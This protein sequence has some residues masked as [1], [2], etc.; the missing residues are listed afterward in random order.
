MPLLDDKTLGACVAVGA[1][2]GLIVGRQILSRSDSAGV[3]ITLSTCSSYAGMGVGLLAGIAMQ[4]PIVGALVFGPPA[5][6][7][8]ADVLTH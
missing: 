5:A 6:A 2:S 4:E 1:V 3:R 8:V 7:T